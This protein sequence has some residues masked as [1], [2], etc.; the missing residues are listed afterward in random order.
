[1]HELKCTLCSAKVYAF[2][3]LAVAELMEE[4]LE[5]KHG[6]YQRK[7]PESTPAKSREDLQLSKADEEFLTSMRIG[8]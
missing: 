4:H 6:Y 2:S 8:W 1:M 7:E 5:E 3:S